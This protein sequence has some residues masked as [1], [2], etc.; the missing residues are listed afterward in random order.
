MSEN[1]ISDSQRLR[2]YFEHMLTDVLEYDLKISVTYSRFDIE[3]RL[4]L[5]DQ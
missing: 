3:P 5:Q 1:L 4:M 2:A